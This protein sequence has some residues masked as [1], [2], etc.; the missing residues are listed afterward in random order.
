MF[1][2]ASTLP[3]NRQMESAAAAREVGL[4]DGSGTDIREGLGADNM[5]VACFN[6]TSGKMAFCGTLSLQ[7][8]MECSL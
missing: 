6:P 3:L 2:I 1:Y 7:N 4:T 5:P 8:R